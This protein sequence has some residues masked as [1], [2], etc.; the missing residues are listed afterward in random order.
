MRH[1]FNRKK[2]SL[3]IKTSGMI[4]FHFEEHVAVR[5][6]NGEIGQM[7]TKWNVE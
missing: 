2:Y 1:V 6:C 3:E 7:G 5:V 4:V